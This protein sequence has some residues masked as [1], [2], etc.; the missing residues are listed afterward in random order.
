MATARSTLSLKSFGI[1]MMA[2]FAGFGAADAAA[3]VRMELRKIA[4]NVYLMQHPTGSSNSMF[5]VTDAG[6]FV[7]DGDIRTADQVFAGIRRTTDKKIIYHAISHPAGDHATGGWHFRQDRPIIIGTRT[8]AKSLAAEELEEF[9]TRKRS[10]DALYAPYHNSE[11]VQPDITFDGSL[12]IRFGGL[13]FVLT[14]EGAAHSTSDVSLYI[15]EKRIFA[16]G[17]LFKSE[18]HTGPGDTAY[19]TFR[20][21]KPFMEIAEKVMARRLPVETYVPGHGPAHVGRGA[22]DLQELN[23][24][25]AAMRDEVSKMIRAGKTE[26]QVVAE[27]KMPAPFDKYGQAAGINRFLPLYYRDLKAEGVR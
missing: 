25:F 13:T 18:I 9:T 1:A 2:M 15:P 5:V 6:V 3:P 12:T 26:Q 19:R 4:D 21:G 8:Q 17:D 20:A 22:A 24:Y 11:L 7:W 14:E 10:N 16:M 27:F 23:R